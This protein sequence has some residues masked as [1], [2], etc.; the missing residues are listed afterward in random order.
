MVPSRSVA[1]SATARTKVE[2]CSEME[3][4]WVMSDSE[5]RGQFD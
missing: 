1:W 2:R 3:L 4:E 5:L